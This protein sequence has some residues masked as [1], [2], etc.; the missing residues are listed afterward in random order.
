[1]RTLDVDPEFVNSLV[2][3]PDGLRLVSRPLGEPFIVWDVLAEERIQTLEVS[4]E[5]AYHIVTWSPD[6]SHL[7]S[8]LGIN[9]SII[10]WDGETEHFVGWS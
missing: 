9:G 7:A 2:W 1:M 8:G 3:T 5:E 10:I 4:E 6:G